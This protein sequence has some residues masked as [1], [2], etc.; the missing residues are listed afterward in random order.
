MC[1]SLQFSLPNYIFDSLESEHIIS[2]HVKFDRFTI[3]N[4]FLGDQAIHVRL[5][6]VIRDLESSQR[7]QS[8]IDNTYNDFCGIIQDEMFTKID[9]KVLRHSCLL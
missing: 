4:N 6:D 5:A 1:G 9:Y 8:D 7:A 3:S 2:T